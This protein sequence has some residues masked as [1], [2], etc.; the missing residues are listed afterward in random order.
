MAIRHT[1]RLLAG[2]LT[3]LAMACVWH[4]FAPTGIGG[5]TSYVVTDGISMEPHFHA[6]DLVL[7][8]RQS[9]YGVGEIV[10]YRNTMLGTVVL[11]RIVGR[12][13]VRYVFKGDNNSFKDFEHPAG[14]QLI[15]AL[16]LHLPG[17][18]TRLKSLR[19]PALLG[20]LGAFGAFLL[21]GALF[22]QRRRRRRRRIPLAEQI[23]APARDTNWYARAPVIVVLVMLIALLPCVAFVF[24]RPSRTFAPV[25]VAYTQSGTLSYSA[26]TPNTP[27]YPDGGLSTGDPIF[28]HVVSALQLRFRYLFHS[29]A[30]RS[31]RGKATLRATVTATNGWHMSMRLGQALPFKGDRAQLTATLNVGSLLA[32][33]RRVEA[34]T[35]VGGSYTLT[36]VPHV[37][38]AGTVGSVPLA[39]TFFSQAQFSLNRLEI[40][41]ATAEAGRAGGLGPFSHVSSG[42]LVGRRYMPLR[43]LRVP[44]ATARGLVLGTIA[45]LIC[46]LLAIVKLV[47]SRVGEETALILKRYGQVIISVECVWQLPGVAVID[48]EE[49][50]ALRRIAERYDRSILHEK[51]DW[52]DAFWVT[53]ESGHFR[54]AVLSPSRLAEAERQYAR[55]SVSADQTAEWVVEEPAEALSEGG[56]VE[57]LVRDVALNGNWSAQAEPL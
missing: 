33:L 5:S 54:Y 24:S 6:G 13:G 14:S 10:A 2:A 34:A 57:E 37:E 38:T 39:T 49:M 30:T 55:A 22:A 27:V 46:L 17:A 50:E 32:L 23:E 19:S 18:G 1:K 4:Y 44:I 45:I 11:H 42:S 3:L 40:Q 52:G 56:Q 25:K 43:V 35:A 8:R 7:V 29:T 47:R 41:P 9:S 21:G 26:P 36:L 20:V 53:D 51:A 16:W 31:I 15:G 28:T 12:S 48:V